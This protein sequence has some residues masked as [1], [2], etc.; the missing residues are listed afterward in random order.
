[1]RVRLH[2]PAPVDG[3]PGLA[4]HGS[5]TA[6]GQGNVHGITGNVSLWW[7]DD[8]PLDG[9]IEGPALIGEAISVTWVKPGWSARRDGDGHLHLRLI[10]DATR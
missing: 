10:E 4:V 5:G 8:L 7:R 1:M 6:F 3:F 2:A 9:A